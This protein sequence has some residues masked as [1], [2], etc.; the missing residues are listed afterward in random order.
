MGYG[1]R[2]LRRGC[3]RD[4]VVVCHPHT[5]LYL[6]QPQCPAFLLPSHM[7]CA[8]QVE[9]VFAPGSGIFK[10]CWRI[11]GT[12]VIRFWRQ[13]SLHLLFQLPW[14][15]WVSRCSWLSAWCSRAW[16]DGKAVSLLGFVFFFLPERREEG[17]IQE[18]VGRSPWCLEGHPSLMPP[19]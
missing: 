2:Q 9:A 16:F 6:L 10:Q 19:D 12:P 1:L 11:S 18:R 5:P 14:I 13:I 3:G 8:C 15:C 17:I 4:L 7:P